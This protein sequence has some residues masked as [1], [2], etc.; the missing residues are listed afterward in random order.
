SSRRTRLASVFNRTL[1]PANPPLRDRN[2]R[3]GYRQAEIT[4]EPGECQAFTEYLVRRS[5]GDPRTCMQTLSV[6]VDEGSAGD[7]AE[8]VAI[9]ERNVEDAAREERVLPGE[10]LGPRALAV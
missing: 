5:G 7:A 10:R 6:D 1:I 2:V 9:R 8:R 4:G 3:S